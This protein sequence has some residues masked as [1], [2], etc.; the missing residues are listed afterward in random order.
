MWSGR[1]PGQSTPVQNRR[2]PCESKEIIRCAVVADPWRCSQPSC[3]RSARSRSTPR[4]RSGPRSAGRAR[5]APPTGRT[6][7]PTGMSRRG[8]GVRW[9]A[10]VPGVGHSSPIVWGDRLFLTTAVPA[11][12][13]ALVLGD[14]G[15]IDL[16]ADKPPISWRLLC[17]G[18]SDGKLLWER[19]A[20]AGAPRAARHV[21]SSQ[22]NP[23]P[24]T[25]GKT[26]VALLASGT[27]VAYDIGGHEALEHGPR[28][29]QPGPARRP[30]VRVGSRELSRDLR[31]PRDRAGGQARG[32]LPRGLRARRPASRS[33]GWRATSARYGRRRRSTPR[34]AGP[35]SWSSAAT[36]C[37]ATTRAPARSCGASRT[38]RRS[39]RPRR[40]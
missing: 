31:R 28:H 12:S 18:A 24:V 3:R 19:E 39:R 16:A 36:P 34:R 15:G 32:F 37:G 13:P 1:R 11:E 4:P 5:K 23:T 14:K 17:I 33:G 20:Y 30:E 8:R 6:C 26:V 38:R 27:L 21:K 40:S 7:R 22:A 35:S 2:T 9:K 29:A 25:D 10:A